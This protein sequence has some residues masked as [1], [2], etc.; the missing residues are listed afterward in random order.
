MMTIVTQVTLKEGTEP[1]WDAIMRD[2]MAVVSDR[3]GWVGGQLLIPVDGL[4]KRVI[5][6]TWETRAAWEAWHNDPEFRQTRAQ[7]ES[8]EAAPGQ[9][10]WHEVIEDIR[11]STDGFEEAA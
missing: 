7:L 10:W 5:V 11:R 4:N 1:E 3:P 9:H 6:G 8:L 2:R